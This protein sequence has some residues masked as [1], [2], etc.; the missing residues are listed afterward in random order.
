M[1]Q[2]LEALIGMEYPGR[3]IVIGKSPQGDD[4]IMYAITGRSPSS[5]ARRLEIDEENK[6]VFVKPTD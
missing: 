6:N 3:V 1:A 5:Q 2:G 4:V